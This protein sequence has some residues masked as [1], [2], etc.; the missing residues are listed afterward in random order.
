MIKR[1]LKKT[2]YGNTLILDYNN[3]DILDFSIGY[4]FSNSYIVKKCLSNGGM[5]AQAFKDKL[6]STV[7]FQIIPA[8]ISPCESILIFRYFNKNGE[9]TFKMTE[10]K[11]FLFRILSDLK[12]VNVPIKEIEAL[13]K[14][15]DHTYQGEQIKIV[16][17][18]SPNNTGMF[19]ND[20]ELKFNEDFE[21]PILNSD[22]IDY[23][24]YGTPIKKLNADSIVIKLQEKQIGLAIGDYYLKKDNKFILY[25]D[26][27]KMNGD[28]E[29]DDPDKLNFEKYELPLTANHLK[30][31][32]K[33]NKS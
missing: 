4:E 27:D 3:N 12:S 6:D 14:I 13:N 33:H 31:I 22:I 5:F 18:D 8:L 11:L 29:I 20:K 28:F 19:V 32:L 7:L 16:Q 10:T 17:L 26:I 1:T 30:Y 15:S 21:M 2:N 23:T 9:M 25:M 24:Y